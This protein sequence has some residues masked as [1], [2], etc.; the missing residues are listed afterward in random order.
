MSQLD[1]PARR[2][3]MP[4][5]ERLHLHRGQSLVETQRGRECSGTNLPHGRIFGRKRLP[6]PLRRARRG[7]SLIEFA[8]VAL[9]VYLLLAAILT[10]GHALY[11]AQG[12]QTAVDLAAREIARTPLPVNDTFEEALANPL[13][14]SAIYS[15][16][17]LV[18][19]LHTLD[20]NQS[21]F[22]DIVPTWPLLNQQLATLMIVD[23][24][25][26][27]LRLLRYPGALLTNSST[28]TG[29]TVG[30]PVVVERDGAG[31]ET[32]RWV[33]VVEEIEPSDPDEPRHNPFQVSSELRGVVAL[34][35]NYPFQSASMSSFRPNPGGPFEPTIGSPNAADDGQVSELNADARPGNLLGIP[36]EDDQGLYAGT[37]GGQYGLGAQGALGSQQLTGG[38]PVRPY[39]RVI[40]AQAIYRREVFQ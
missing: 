6:T 2:H 19:D 34:R 7:Q 40:S 16:D 30:I 5:G 20:A 1:S 36:L 29:F 35:I 23:N 11:V 10:F 38:R 25:I 18:F 15:D 26:P 33:P 13:V 17:Y 31:I 37:Y 4:P 39:R 8:L 27:G 24:S 12:L 9:V 32:I 21:F 28:P 22:Q 14:Q 3:A